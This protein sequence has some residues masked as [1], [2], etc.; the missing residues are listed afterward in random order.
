MDLKLRDEHTIVPPW[1]YR[2]SEQTTREEFMVLLSEGTCG[3]E[4]Y[5]ELSRA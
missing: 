3:H 5:V 4:R 1:P 2:A